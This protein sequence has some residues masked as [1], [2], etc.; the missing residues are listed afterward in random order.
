MHE[1]KQFEKPVQNPLKKRGEY[2]IFA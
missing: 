1:L 2:M